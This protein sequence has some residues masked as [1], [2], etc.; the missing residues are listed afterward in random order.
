MRAWLLCLALAGCA[1]VSTPVT[2]PEAQ[3]LR[4]AYV[5]SH[6]NWAFSGR[7]AYTH[8]GKG[9]T[10]QIFWQQTG[11]KAELRLNAPLSLGSARIVFTPEYAQLFDGAGNQVQS[12]PTAQLLESLLGVP[13]PV[14]DFARGI[15]GGFSVPGAQAMDGWQ[16]QYGKWAS[17][18]ALLP[19][20]IELRRNQSRLRLV[21]DRWQELGND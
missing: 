10:A 3:R 13:V 5:D 12:G 14:E 16:W 15:R 20:Q 1:T 19:T 18:P 17:S 21:V 6:P 7:L 11:S 9:G 8:D 4:Q 2:S